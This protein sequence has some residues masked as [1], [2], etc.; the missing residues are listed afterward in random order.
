MHF[1]PT[2]AEHIEA[3]LL[4][5]V[6]NYAL[7][8]PLLRTPQ[9]PAKLASYVL[10]GR[11]IYGLGL[12]VGEASRGFCTWL[13]ALTSEESCDVRLRTVYVHAVWFRSYTLQPP[14]VC[15]VSNILQTVSAMRIVLTSCRHASSLRATSERSDQLPVFVSECL[16]CA[17]L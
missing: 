13:Q 12:V 14:I 1:R 4:Q 11:K 7:I 17:P 10:D 5:H 9:V 3:W 6:M 16:P 15:A 8:S 2:S